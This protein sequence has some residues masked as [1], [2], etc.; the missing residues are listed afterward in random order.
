LLGSNV[1][2]EANLPAAVRSLGR[3]GRIAAISNVYESAPVGFLDQPNF[4]NAAVLLETEQSA[5]SLRFE[6]IAEIERRLGRT[7]DPANKNAPRTI[8]IDI[9][10]FNRDVVST[11]GLR[12]PG[13]DILERLFAARP[14]ADVDPDYVHPETGSTLRAIADALEKTRKPLILRSDVV[15]RGD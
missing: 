10:L 5:E 8:D 12:I 13:P 3:F 9:A 2:P 7:R 14:L 6:T 1:A 4:L 11:G 15:L